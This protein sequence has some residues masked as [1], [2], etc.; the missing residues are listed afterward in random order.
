MIGAG[1]FDDVDDL[2]HDGRLFFLVGCSSILLQERA[3]ND[4]QPSVSN[5]LTASLTPSADN[6]IGKWLEVERKRCIRLLL[7]GILEEIEGHW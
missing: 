2:G 4:F 1:V 5:G 3:G 7:L 6:G